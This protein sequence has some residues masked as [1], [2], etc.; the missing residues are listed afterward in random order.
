MM[1]K[2]LPAEYS[3]FSAIVVHGEE[4]TF[5]KF[6]VALK[7]HEE[8]LKPHAESGS[9]IM[10]ITHAH[11]GSNNALITCFKC[12][13]KGHKAPACKKRSRNKWCDI[14]KVNA[15]KYCRKNSAKSATEVSKNAPTTSN[16]NE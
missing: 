2:G 6:K 15:T 1:I 16:T 5:S 3:T 4:M 13:E 7:S 12:G 8:T 11:G 9:S 10:N 14:C